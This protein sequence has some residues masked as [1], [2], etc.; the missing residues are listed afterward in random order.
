MSSFIMFVVLWLH[1]ISDL[2]TEHADRHCINSS[3]ASISLMSQYRSQSMLQVNRDVTR[4]HL[5]TKGEK[6]AKS[7]TNLSFQRLPGNRSRIPC[8]K[9]MNQVNLDIHKVSRR[10]AQERAEMTPN[11]K[12]NLSFPRFQNDSGRLAHAPEKLGVIDCGTK[13]GQRP[14]QYINQ[15]INSTLQATR[16]HDVALL[17]LASLEAIRTQGLIEGLVPLVLLMLAI[18][19]CIVWCATASTSDVEDP[20][21]R[22]MTERQKKYWQGGEHIVPSP[23]VSYPQSRVASTAH[24]VPSR[25][26]VIASN[27]S[28][29]L[30]PSS[31]TSKAPASD[32]SFTERSRPTVPKALTSS[33]TSA[34]AP[35]LH[36]ANP[37]SE[38]FSTRVDDATQS[39]VVRSMA[40]VPTTEQLSIGQ[41]QSASGPSPPRAAGQSGHSTSTPYAVDLVREGLGDVRELDQTMITTS[42]ASR[43]RGREAAS[44]SSALTQNEL[45]AVLA[46]RQR[47]V[48]AS[49][50]RQ[51]LYESPRGISA[52][53]QDTR[54]RE[55]DEILNARQRMVEASDSQREL[56]NS[57]SKNVSQNVREGAGPSELSSLLAERQRAVE[58]SNSQRELYQSPRARMGKSPTPASRAGELEQVL[59]K[60]RIDG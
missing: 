49:G 7:K 27:Q 14:Q 57:P 47:L 1:G 3:P 5:Q 23:S 11:L 43:S 31:L 32:F 4:G 55:L 18:V 50:S 41:S 15:L 40:G 6:N 58:A 48:E 20:S 38:Y 33:A 44:S 59:A 51:R 10:R 12:T 56:W 46:E 22:Q 42:I 21:Q 25:A 60:R 28:L 13:I 45:D 8:A 19:G 2:F 26:D 24:G 36:V 30:K 17:A 9:E 16:I 35:S 29:G 54:Q 39:R 52:L 34:H 53:A 37:Y